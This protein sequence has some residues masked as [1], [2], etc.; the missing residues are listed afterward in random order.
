MS[1]SQKQI[2]IEKRRKKNG[3]SKKKKLTRDW[4]IKDQ[5][6]RVISVQPLGY[7]RTFFVSKEVVRS[8]DES[9]FKSS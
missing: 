7:V 6:N 8:F 9:G 4:L 2:R 5:G 1:I 3:Y